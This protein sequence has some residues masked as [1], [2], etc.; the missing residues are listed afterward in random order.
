[1]TS[2]D[3][4]QCELTPPYGRELLDGM[5]RRELMELCKLHDIKC[6]GKVICEM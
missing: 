5:K 2:D 1:M 6:T 3:A 4:E